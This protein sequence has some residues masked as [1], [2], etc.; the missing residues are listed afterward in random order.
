MRQVFILILCIFFQLP[1]SGFAGSYQA[2]E[3]GPVI[4][5]VTR[6]KAGGTKQKGTLNGIRLSYERLKRYGWYVGL[7]GWYAAGKIAGNTGGGESLSSRL[8]DK[9][10]EMK[11]GY[12][13]QQKYQF[14]CAFTPFFCGGYLNEKNRFYPPAPLSVDFT[15]KFYYVGGGLLL[16]V[17]PFERLEVGVNLRVRYPIEPKCSISNGIEENTPSQQIAERL[18]YFLE[19]PILYR[20]SCDEKWILGASPFYESRLYGSHPNYPYNYY[21]TKFSNWG[22]T[23][24]LEYRI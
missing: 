8:S 1:L 14:K 12:T 5:E 24:K 10:L 7:E 16:R 2:I 15:T 19:M 13:F 22:V 6:K 4:Y 17:Q 11:M 20:I 23:L 3:I 9:Y 21:K 18:Q